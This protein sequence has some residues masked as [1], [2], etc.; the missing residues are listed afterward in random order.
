M[1][2]IEYIV[3]D[4]KGAERLR[5]TDKKAADA[6]DRALESAERLAELLRQD[7]VVPG[8]SEREM[9]DLT[10]YLVRNSKAVERILKGK[11]VE[12]SVEPESDTKDPGATV[13]T[14]RAA[15]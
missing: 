15:V 10:I 5:T 9:E 14:L 8:L 3:R 4:Q 12:T 1:I 6:Y 2:E 11:S 7:E 13:T